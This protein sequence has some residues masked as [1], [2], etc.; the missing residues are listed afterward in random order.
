MGLID[1]RTRLIVTVEPSVQTQF[2]LDSDPPAVELAGAYTGIRMLVEDMGNEY[3]L[4]VRGTDIEGT[5]PPDDEFLLRVISDFDVEPLLA[6]RASLWC[7][8]VGRW[9]ELGSTPLTYTAQTAWDRF[10]SKIPGYREA[11][12]DCL[13]T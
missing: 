8:P 5:L 12:S 1:I 13:R 4:S 6:V 11:R 10:L 7:I 9:L 2:A 3:L